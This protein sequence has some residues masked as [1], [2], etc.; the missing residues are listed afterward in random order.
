MAS[1][2]HICP[3]CGDTMVSGQ[4]ALNRHWSNSLLFGW[5][6]SVLQIKENA[7]KKWHDFMLPSNKTR[8]SYC[9][10]CGALLIAPSIKHHREELGL[11]N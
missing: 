8:C 7:S 4:A 3:S 9:T 11:E 5:G 1:V 6:S 2:K 10:S